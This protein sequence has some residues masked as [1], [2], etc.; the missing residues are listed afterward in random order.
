MKFLINMMMGDKE[1]EE[2]KR[3]EPAPLPTGPLALGAPTVGM[4]SPEDGRDT[5]SPI[6]GESTMDTNQ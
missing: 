1:T 4:Y 5:K 3:E 6:P 2:T